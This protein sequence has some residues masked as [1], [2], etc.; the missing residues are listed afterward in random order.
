VLDAVHSLFP[1]ISRV[2]AA[3]AKG[4]L[5]FLG[6]DEWTGQKRSL[7]VTWKELSESSWTEEVEASER[8]GPFR[9]VVT[10]KFE[11]VEEPAAVPPKP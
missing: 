5:A 1:G 6:E 9:P 7:R 2:A 10:V 4:A 3:D 8:G 11:R